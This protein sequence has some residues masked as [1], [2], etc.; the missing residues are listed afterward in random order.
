MIQQ[1]VEVPICV[2]VE[3]S[4]WMVLLLSVAQ[5]CAVGYLRSGFGMCRLLSCIHLVAT[6]TLTCRCYSAALE[7]GVGTAKR[8]QTNNKYWPSK[9]FVNEFCV[10]KLRTCR[11]DAVHASVVLLITERFVF[12]TGLLLH[13]PDACH[14]TLGIDPGLI[15]AHVRSNSF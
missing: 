1:R 12:S 14:T 10:V 2:F 5:R 7:R 13:M 9:G 15:L 11:R 6:G 3:H 4:P 8:G